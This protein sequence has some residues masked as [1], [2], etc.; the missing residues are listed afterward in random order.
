MKEKS[1]Y[2]FISFYFLKMI[3]VIVLLPVAVPAW[4][5]SAQRHC[6]YPSVAV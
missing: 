1:S 6:N 5:N 4:E 2:I 3:L